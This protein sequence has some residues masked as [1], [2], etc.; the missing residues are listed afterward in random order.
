MDLIPK[1]SFRIVLV[2]ND[3]NDVF[4][5]KRALDRAG[6]THPL[7]RLQ[8]GQFAIEYFSQ[9]PPE[10]WPNAVLLDLNMPRRD[11]FAVLEW[12]RRYPT[13]GSLPILMLTSSED[14]RDM[15]KAQSLQAKF[16]C[17]RSPYHN[18]I[19]SLEELRASSHF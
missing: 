5:L 10:Q 16:L 15:E 18:V 17:K 2:E 3:D 12:F 13:Y 1:P 19:A 9:I 7:T 8:D 14:P 6:F 11:G 4:F